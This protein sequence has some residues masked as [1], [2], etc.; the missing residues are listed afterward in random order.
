[1]TV[2][3][4]TLNLAVEAALTFV[5]EGLDAAMNRFNGVMT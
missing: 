1:M 4:E 5:N 3:S 2:I